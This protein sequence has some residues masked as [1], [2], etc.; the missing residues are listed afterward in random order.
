MH[1]CEEERVD[2]WMDGWEGCVKCWSTVFYAERAW[3]ILREVCLV[4]IWRVDF[5]WLLV[6]RW[7]GGREGVRVGRGR[8]GGRGDTEIGG[9]R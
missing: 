4:G 8:K 9:E 2:E 1:V 5:R 7:T 3:V 6:G